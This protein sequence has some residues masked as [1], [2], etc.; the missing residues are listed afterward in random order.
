MLPEVIFHLARDAKTQHCNINILYACAVICW[1][2][3][4]VLDIPLYDKVCQWLATARW[5]STGYSS[6]F[7]Q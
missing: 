6:F 3:R 2:R 4:G 5:F 1:I 7:H